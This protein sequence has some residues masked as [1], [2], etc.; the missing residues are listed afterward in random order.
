[1]AGESGKLEVMLREVVPSLSL[2]FLP[3]A[4]PLPKVLEVLNPSP[5]LPASIFWNLLIIRS[6]T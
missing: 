4:F 1:M 2:S 6:K 3:V 5:L